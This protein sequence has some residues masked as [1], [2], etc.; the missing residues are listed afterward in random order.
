MEA[1]NYRPLFERETKYAVPVNS[2][3]F[4]EPLPLAGV[5]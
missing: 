1:T 2:Q 3:F 5:I 4:T